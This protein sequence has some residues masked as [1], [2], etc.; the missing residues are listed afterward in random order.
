MKRAF[1]D[2]RGKNG[3][4]ILFGNMG[5]PV[6]CRIWEEMHSE[7]RIPAPW[8]AATTLILRC[9][10]SRF[11]VSAKETRPSGNPSAELFQRVT[12]QT[13]NFSDDEQR[14]ELMKY[15]SP[16]SAKL[17]LVTEQYA[18]R[19]SGDAFVVQ[20]TVTSFGGQSFDKVDFHRN[21][22]ELR[23]RFVRSVADA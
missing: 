1:A 8:C 12:F 21:G 17:E 13:L 9:G 19:V 3:C 20:E 15:E 2:A 11:D 7:W 10:N 16:T 14:S 22:C 4:P 18:C 23:C 5:Q 6:V